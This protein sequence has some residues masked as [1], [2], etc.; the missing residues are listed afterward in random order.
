MYSHCHNL[1]LKL[2][3]AAEAAAHLLHF[4]G[5]FD[6]FVDRAD[7]VER[8]LGQVIVIAAQDTL[9]TTDGFFQ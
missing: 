4:F 5:F 6:R 2:E 7:H 8:L 1:P 9:E 3:G